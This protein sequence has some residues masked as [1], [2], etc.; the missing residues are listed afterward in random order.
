MTLHRPETLDAALAL[1]AEGGGVVLAGGTDVYPGLR[2]A[3]PPARMIDVSAVAGLRGIARV[4]E[5]WRIGAATTWTDVVRADLPALFD[6]LKLA[7]REVGSV[8][9][10]NT[11]T[12]AGNLCNAS[13]AADGVPALMALDAEVELTGPSGAR[14][15][16]LSAFIQ[17]VRKVDLA[18]GELMTAI[19]VHD[20]PGCGAFRKLGARRYLVISIA[21]VSAVV[22][23]DGGRIVR[24]RIAVG[25]CSPV[26][27]RL[28]DLET[29][30][31]GAA[32]GDVGGI[33][34]EARLDALTPIDDVRASAVFR[35]DAVRTLVRR[36]LLDAVEKTDVA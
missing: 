11:G 1:L 15:V 31:V 23:A 21:M 9:I 20:A 18:A 4:D 24:A 36:T 19:Y 3:P 17:G 6:G 35:M 13:P 32:L 26:A 7:A 28:V 25:S 2:A 5:G 12:V 34:G 33:V 22:H 16:P 14:R 27:R 29:A 30:L 8:Q 10:Q